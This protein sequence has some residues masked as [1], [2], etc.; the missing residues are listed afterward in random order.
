MPSKFTFAGNNTIEILYDA[1]GQK[2][3]KLVKTAGVETL[4]QDYLGGIEVKNNKIEAIYNEEGRAYNTNND[5]FQWRYEY[6]LKDHLGNT[7]VVF[8]DKN[9]N[10]KI[11]DQTE[12]LQ[13][14][15]YYPFGMAFNG[16][17]YADNTASKYKYLY[18][19]K[20]LNEDFGLNLSDYGARWYDASIGRW[21]NVDP[22]AE[23][24]RR[25][26][27]YHYGKDNPIRFID[28]DGMKAEEYFTFYDRFKAENDRELSKNNKQG[29][30]EPKK[31]AKI[32]E[33]NVYKQGSVVGFKADSDTQ[34]DGAGTAHNKDPKGQGQTKLKGT[35]G[36]SKGGDIDPTQISSTVIPGGSAGKK[37]IAAGIYY[38]DLAFSYNLKTEKLTYSI[39]ADVGP[40]GKLG[41]NSIKAQDELGIKG[42]AYNGEQSNIVMTFIFSGSRAYFTDPNSNYYTNGTMPTQE[43]INVLGKQLYQNNMIPIGQITPYLLKEPSVTVF[44]N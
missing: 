3:R 23:V 16:S 31:I 10:G 9:K 24:T 43:T 26:S 8:C 40:S 7:R 1:T 12:I 20:E 35:R 30:D 27:P 11:E 17:W 33:A 14:T 15:H 38:G 42:D 32:K 5:P 18:N 25:Y 13:E 34:T 4:R 22:L 36:F 2:L 21:W 6:N 29:G 39:L 41:E 44:D 19:G 37:M 28:R